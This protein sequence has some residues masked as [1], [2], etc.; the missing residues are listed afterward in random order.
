MKSENMHQ[1]SAPYAP[2]QNIV[3]E[4]VNRTIVEKRQDAYCFDAHTTGNKILGN[5]RVYGSFEKIILKGHYRNARRIV[6]K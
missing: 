2:E 6:V 5:S 1:T 3:S 4:R